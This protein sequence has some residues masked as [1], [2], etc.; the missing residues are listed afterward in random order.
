MLTGTAL[1]G[2]GLHRARTLDDAVALLA[3][4]PGARPLAGATWLMRTHLRRERPPAELVDVTAIP[5]LRTITCAEGISTIGA[6]V[7]HRELATR[8]GSGPAARWH[9]GL[10]AAAAAAANPAVRE[11]A[12]VG[13]NLCAVGFPAADLVPALLAAD[14]EVVVRAPVT[15]HIAVADLLADPLR[16]RPGLLVEAV[17][18]PHRYPRSAH[19]RLPLRAAGDYPAV[20]VSVAARLAEDGRVE[21]MRVALGA[22]A[23]VAFRWADL[24]HALTGERLTA[25]SAHTAAADL[26]AGLPAR[27]GLD[28]D[29][30]YR[31]EVTPALVRRAV[32]ALS[33]AR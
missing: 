1:T 22:V 4:A 30:W 29:A 14:A 16:E 25:E 2:T 6:A 15:R 10:V 9:R 13:G 28:A 27:D 20:I 5:E 19:V 33:E 12:T 8:V 24:E 7:T 23:A 31:R 17:R 3:D 11:I 32:G 26:R 18:V 21:R